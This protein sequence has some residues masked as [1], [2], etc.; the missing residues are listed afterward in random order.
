[1]R[2]H[3]PRF[4]LTA[5]AGWLNDPNALAYRDGRYH[6]FYQHNPAATVWGDVH[7]GHAAS[8]DLLRW[9]HLPIALSPTPGGPDADGCWSGC[10]VDDDGV[11]TL[12]YS[13]FV[14]PSSIG[15]RTVCLARGD[16][17]LVAWRTDERNPVLVAPDDPDA[18]AF[19]DPC[20]WGTPGSWTLVLGSGRGAEQ[21]VL[22]Q[23]R[24]EN[25]LDWVYDGVLLEG[26]GGRAWECP[27]LFPLADRHVLLV[28]VWDD[29]LTPETQ[30]VD[31]IVG[32]YDGTRFRPE[33][34]TRLDH[35]ADFYAAATMLDARG[36]RLV[37]GW[38]WEAR[39]PEAAAE[40]GWAGTLT[41]PRALTL[42]ADGT[43]RLALVEEL[44]SL[45]GPE[46]RLED[47]RLG[48][49][50]RLALRTRADCLDLELRARCDPGAVLELDLCSSPGRDERT[51]VR[52]ES[53]TG[54]LEV[55]R[56]H[57]SL[58]P[59]ATKGAHG[60][61]LVL[62]PDE[63]LELRV[64]VDRSIV[65]V[66]ANGR[67]SLTERIYPT[68]AGSRGLA[69]SATGGDATVQHLAVRPLTP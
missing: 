37:L 41:L 10:L 14:A 66:I 2:D 52:F 60:G 19:R 24:S 47:V 23:Y 16:D 63:P 18:V 51:T 26:T 69:L 50:R 28:S 65:E 68:L 38:S 22:L 1:M 20:V 57:A 27:Q 49:G 54:R 31:A 21:P 29:R 46:E 33:T 13:G 48:T 56:D 34:A 9:D 59:R 44:A 8:S 7:W 61:H 32:A 15:A 11:P 17:A 6:A 53:T 58:D 43:L 36:R 64:V 5:P 25:L 3:R 35:G 42:H 40:Q 12:V 45:R 55:D 39:A 4:H 67:L 30:H 62:A